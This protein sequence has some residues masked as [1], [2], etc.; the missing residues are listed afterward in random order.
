MSNYDID[1]IKTVHILHHK[2]QKKS[3]EVYFHFLSNNLV[4]SYSYFLIVFFHLVLQWLMHPYKQVFL[5]I[6]YKQQ[7][8]PS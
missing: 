6:V 2:N 7:V 3:I 8:T 5:F 4:V 1:P